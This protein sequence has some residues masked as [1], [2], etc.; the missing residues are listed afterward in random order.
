[1]FGFS[2]KVSDPVCKMKVDKTKYSSEY[3]GVKYYF[4][5]QDCIKNFNTEPEKYIIQQE[6]IP[7]QSC[8]Q[9]SKK[10]CC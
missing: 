2:Q 4:C 1:M 3:K 9:Q 8:C 10:S 6:N 5:S 7:A